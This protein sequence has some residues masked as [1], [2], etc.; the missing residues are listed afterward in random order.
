M[1]RML[2]SNHQA[3]RGPE[4]CCGC[5]G[6]AQ[7]RQSCVQRHLQSRA[8]PPARPAR[9]GCPAAAPPSSCPTPP[10]KVASQA[11]AKLSRM[12]QSFMRDLQGGY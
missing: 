8:P 12:A 3:G 5:V 2:V 11:G 7:R 4:C 10:L 6:W 9:P 1:V